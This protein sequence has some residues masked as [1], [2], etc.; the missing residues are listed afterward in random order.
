MRE[1]V[2]AIIVEFGGL[3]VMIVVMGWVGG[4][5]KIKYATCVMLSGITE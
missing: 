2:F 5:H 4:D 3:I 1:I